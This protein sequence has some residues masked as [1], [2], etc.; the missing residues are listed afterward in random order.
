M[1]LNSRSEEFE[2]FLKK[3]VKATVL[4]TASVYFTVFLAELIFQ[5]ALSIRGKNISD[6]GVSMYGSGGTLAVFF[7]VTV[8]PASSFA[9]AFLLK[10]TI[11]KSSNLSYLVVGVIAALF[12][13]LRFL[14]L[15][16]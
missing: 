1:S 9:L 12:L 2:D 15:L 10:K 8:F 16:F 14:M 11:G 7:W 3:A 5:G 4:V 13:L 6:I